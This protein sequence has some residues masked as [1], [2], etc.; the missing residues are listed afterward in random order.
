MVTATKQLDDPR[1]SP[2]LTTER[3]V[4]YAIYQKKNRRVVKNITFVVSNTFFW[5]QIAIAKCQNASLK[6]WT[7]GHRQEPCCQKCAKLEKEN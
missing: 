5:T 6:V 4:L 3:A 2:L 7:F 1:A